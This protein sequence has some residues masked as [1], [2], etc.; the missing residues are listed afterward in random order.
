MERRMDVVEI[1]GWKSERRRLFS[2]LVAWAERGRIGLRADP[3]ANVPSCL[4]VSP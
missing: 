2:F 4:V 1:H 3:Y